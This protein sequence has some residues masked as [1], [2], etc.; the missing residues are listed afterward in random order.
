MR[1]ASLLVNA[2]AGDIGPLVFILWSGKDDAVFDVALHLPDV[3]GM[4]LSDVHDQ[5]SDLVLVLIVELVEGGN[6]TPEWRS[7][8]AAKDHHDGLR[9]V[10]FGKANGPT[11]VQFRQREIG[12]RVADVNRSG[13]SACPHG[14]KRAYQKYLPSQVHHHSSKC[15]RRTMPD[16]PH[17]ADKTQPQDEDEYEDSRRDFLPPAWWRRGT[18][19][20]NGICRHVEVLCYCTGSILLITIAFDPPRSK[21]FPLT[22]TFLPANGSSL[23]FWLLDGVLSAIGQ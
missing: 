16:S 8:V 19:C 23:S 4:R 10:Q 6:L 12:C 5:E 7:S 1:F 9:L 11:L 13:T 3:A 15:L 14:F 17:K 18:R 21:T 2:G 20:R 22:L